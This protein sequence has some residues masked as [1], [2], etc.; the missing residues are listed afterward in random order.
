M[1][2]IDDKRDGLQTDSELDP[3]DE[4][5]KRINEKRIE[6]PEG[7]ETDHNISEA[8]QIIEPVA[9]TGEETGPAGETE[10][11][12]AAE[13]TDEFIEDE[14][15][16]IRCRKN[17]KD[18]SV[19]E[20]YEFCAECRAEML[21]APLNWKGF[22]AAIVM[23]IV[24]GFAVVIAG[25][26]AMIAMPVVEADD[27]AGQKRLN[28][29]VKSY[30][31]ADTAAAD[32][33]TQFKMDNLF[34]PGTKTFVK[35]I[36]VTAK[37][38]EISAG[39]TLSSIITDEKDYN[40]YL[41]KPLKQYSDLYTALVNTAEVA[42][43]IISE[44]QSAKAADVPYDDLIAQLD[45]LKT[46]A[47]SKKYAAYYIEY[48]KYYAAVFAKKGS[49]TELK[50]LLEV[51]KLA[52]SANWLYFSQLTSVYKSLGKTDKILSECDKLIAINSNSTQAYSIK[53]RVYCDQKDFEKALSI[54]GDMDK[55]NKGTA[56]VYAL[57][58]E[59]YRRKGDLKTAETFCTDGIKDSE[60]S[61]ELYRQQAIVL[62]LKGEKFK[63]KAYEAA[64]NAYNSAYYNGDTTLELLNTIALCASIAGEKD[65][66][67]ETVGYLEESGYKLAES[68]EQ[69]IAGKITL[70]EIFITGKGD[71]L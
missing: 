5:L 53:A 28:D 59:I 42:E 29:A 71:V 55:N 37:F 44:Y 11:N 6:V 51:Q 45:A 2:F 46:G 19:S 54:S 70:K 23:I 17:H 61:T 39:Q 41:L 31:D 24:A 26:T 38:S 14:T 62:M 63:S 20:D 7:Q 64:Y 33:N 10:A 65:M 48:C 47:N 35:K 57:N 60:G 1:A 43:P 66:Y 18:T 16:C 56:A 36:Q 22:L 58:A 50:H 25:Y 32:L 21:K 69:Y 12:N 40:N 9:E 30:A 34:T 27:Y 3:V 52:P 68:V 15:I 4:I 8:E 49:A 67:K 13:D